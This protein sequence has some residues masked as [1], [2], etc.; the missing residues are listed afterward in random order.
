MSA[1]NPELTLSIWTVYKTPRDY[2]NSWVAVRWEIQH[3]REGRTDEL[4]VAPFTAE[5]LGGIRD[6]MQRRGLTYMPRYQ[7]DDPVIFETWI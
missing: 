4:I 6:E 2:P 3:G 7:A 5:G 1:Q